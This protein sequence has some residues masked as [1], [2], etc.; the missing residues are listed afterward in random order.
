M[1][2]RFYIYKTFFLY[3]LLVLPDSVA[4]LSF[5][6]ANE[7]SGQGSRFS[8]LTGIV[9]VDAHPSGIML[10]FIFSFCPF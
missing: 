9:E 5:V 6:I 10:P 7:D 4:I 3:V 1:R 8:G 2:V